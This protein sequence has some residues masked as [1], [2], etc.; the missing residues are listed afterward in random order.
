MLMLLNFIQMVS[1]SKKL[2]MFWENSREYIQLNI[3]YPYKIMVTD[4][5]FLYWSHSP[6]ICTQ[7]GIAY[8]CENTNKIRC[9]WE[10]TSASAIHF[11]MDSVTKTVPWKAK[12][13]INLK[14]EQP[15]MLHGTWLW[16][17][18][19]QSHGH[20]F[21]HWKTDYFQ[22]NTLPTQLLTGHTTLT[23][24]NNAVM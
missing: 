6:K 10:H 21:V 8:Y 24:Q 23:G 2:D 11:Q 18:I 12:H 17:Q 20:W 15:Y 22:W 19:S 7:M 3:Q 16:Y 4:S 9:T 13:A 1:V 5:L 14:P